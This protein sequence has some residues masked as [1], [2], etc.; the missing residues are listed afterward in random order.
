M[1][2]MIKLESNRI[3]FPSPASECFNLV[4]KETLMQYLHRFLCKGPFNDSD[5]MTYTIKIL[6]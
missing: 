5:E 6:Y 1:T 3:C 2:D 4:D